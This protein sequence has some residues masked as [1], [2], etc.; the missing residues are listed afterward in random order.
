MNTGIT[1]RAVLLKDSWERTGRSRD[2]SEHRNLGIGNRGFW[3][4]T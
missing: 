1:K 2:R 3:A 4:V